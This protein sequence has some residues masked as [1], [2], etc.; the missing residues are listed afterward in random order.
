MMLVRADRQSNVEQALQRS[1]LLGS[2]RKDIKWVRPRDTANLLVT[3]NRRFL[4]KPMLY[5]P[6]EVE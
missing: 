2:V 1:N 5:S 6:T 3:I 4:L